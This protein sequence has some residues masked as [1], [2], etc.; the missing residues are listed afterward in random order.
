MDRIF[1]LTLPVVVFLCTLLWMPGPAA[2]AGPEQQRR[3]F[4]QAEE[5]LRKGQRQTFSNLL[6]KL[7]HY[8]LGVYLRQQDLEKRLSLNNAGEVRAFLRD[9]D[10]TPSA[11]ALRRNWL[12]LLARHGR[13]EAFLRDYRPQT[14][15]DLL[16]H[17]GRALLAAGRRTQ[18]W[19][20]ATQLWLS[21]SSRPKSCDPL[22]QEWIAS[23][24]LSRE[25]T[26][27]RIDLA[28]TAGQ[29]KL[30]RYLGR[31]LSPGDKEWLDFWLRVDHSP[32]LVLERDW[33]RTSHDQMDAIIAHGMRKLTRADASRTA[34]DW[35]Q[36]RLRCG[37]D[38]ERYA[39]VENDIL[40]FMSLRFEPDALDQ[41]ASFPEPL[42]TDRVREWAVRTALRR[43]D[44]STVLH[45][46]DLL[47]PAQQ[48]ESR[49]QYWRARA[50]EQSGWTAQSTALFRKLAADHD[51]FGLLALDKLGLKL[52][53]N[54]T[55]MRVSDADLQRVRQ[56]PGLRRAEELHALKRFGPAR[57]EWQQAIA[58]LDQPQLLAAAKWAQHLDWHDRAIVTAVAARHSTDL[59]L[60]FPLPH[61]TAIL[62]QARTKQLDPAWVFGVMRQES[63]FMCDVGSS[64]GAL[65][66]MQIMPQT[67]RRIAG[68]HGEKLSSTALLL[69]PDRNIRYGTTYLRRQLDDLQNHPA[70]ATA[71]YNAGQHRVKG[72]LPA[73]VLPADIWVETIPFNETRNYVE[74]VLA[75]TTI[76]EARLGRTP[77]RLSARLPLIRPADAPSQ[78]AEH[79][80]FSAQP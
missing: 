4:L 71:A 38:R 77:Q 66:L 41:V 76:Y 68:W 17:H 22:F 14:D 10:G 78:V 35:E 36:L 74:K 3:L 63:L 26:W 51:Y 69:Q 40:L 8:P 42:R 61:Q 24:G 65:G 30:A 72:W 57:R 31:F 53:L 1:H 6:A 39:A 54:H 21:G 9:Y 27:Q 11:D 20:Q 47:G 46:L 52:E 70:L 5:A 33:N 29:I 80:V 13:W 55:P 7:E 44:W 62:A 2:S 32:G 48:G 58:D 25:L 49:W 67:G 79:E 16:C 59:E 37:L 34:K 75:Y 64:V 56:L 23:N 28:I 43:Q 45:L 12:A 60:R 19:D 73:S 18:A 15:A 50:L